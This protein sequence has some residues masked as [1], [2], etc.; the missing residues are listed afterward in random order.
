MISAMPILRDT[1]SGAGCQLSFTT[2]GHI[3]NGQARNVIQKTA[4][5]DAPSVSRR[6]MINASAVKKVTS[7]TTSVGPRCAASGL[8][9]LPPILTTIGKLLATNGAKTAESA[10]STIH[11]APS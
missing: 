3:A 10:R 7:S 1:Q 4:A 6:V 11:D 8:D 5:I 2:A 9:H